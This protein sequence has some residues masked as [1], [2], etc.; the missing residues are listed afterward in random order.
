MRVHQSVYVVYKI[1]KDDGQKE[2]KLKI[3]KQ[4]KLN[5][6]TEDLNNDLNGIILYDDTQPFFL[7][8]NGDLRIDMVYVSG[9]SQEP[10]IKLARGDSEDF[11]GKKYTIEY[12]D[13][14]VITPG[15]D[16][17]CVE[18]QDLISSPHSNSY[19]DLNGDC[20][21]DIF[22][23]KTR[24]SQNLK[25]KQPEYINYFEI[26]TQKIQDGKQMYCLF[27]NDSNIVPGDFN[28]SVSKTM[29]GSA[30]LVTFTDVDRDGMMDMV[31]YQDKKIWTYYNMH[32]P[33]NDEKS[34]LCKSQEQLD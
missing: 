33:P 4:D 21:P 6:F 20:M 25:T 29:Q 1:T 5:Q 27:K 14:Y 24:V 16:Q 22:M 13:N 28:V 3:F 34:I 8:L 31:F 12:F 10:K 26:Y 30:P 19:L 11:F 23:Q 7:D 15:Q 32:S 2:T 17:N 18:P 9:D